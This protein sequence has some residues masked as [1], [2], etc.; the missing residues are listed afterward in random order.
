MTIRGR[1]WARRQSRQGQALVEFALV[2]G[3]LLMLLTGV[4]GY[5]LYINAVDTVQF[6]AGQAAGVAALGANLGC[7]GDSAQAQ[8]QAGQPPTIY[9]V[10]D[11]DINNGFAMSDKVSAS[12][13]TYRA[14]ITSISE[15]PDQGDSSLDIVTVTVTYAMNLVIP[16][17]GL[18]NPV[19]ISKTANEV[20]ET[21][22]SPTA[23]STGACTT[24]S[25]PQ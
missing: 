1:R 13:P 2:A 21:T 19:I 20:A 15:V 16:T 24:Q 7:P 4:V 5:G 25:V 3:L 22:V 9:G 17:P 14:M 11:D 10:V 18:A 23:W 8:S 12:P 6:A